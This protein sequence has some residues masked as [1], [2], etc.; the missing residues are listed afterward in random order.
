M[1]IM[2]G[3]VMMSMVMV[4]VDLIGFGNDGVYVSQSTGSHFEK[5]KKWNKKFGKEDGWNTKL[6]ARMVGD[7]NGD[8]KEI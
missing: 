4:Q 6:H 3:L 7:V 8:G 2:S 1:L 5:T